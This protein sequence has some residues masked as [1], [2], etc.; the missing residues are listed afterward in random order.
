MSSFTFLLPILILAAI[1]VPMIL[2][3]LRKAKAEREGKIMIGM[4]REVHQTGTYINEQPVLRVLMDAQSA[5]GQ[6]LQTTLK[7]VFS[8]VDPPRAGMQLPIVLNPQNPAEAFLASD[9][10]LQR[11]DRTAEVLR[12]V[13]AVPPKMRGNKP[14]VGDIVAIT[15]LPDGK[16]SYQV[17]V[18]R[19]NRKPD[20]VFCTQQFAPGEAAFS[21]GDRV[22]LVTDA[23]VP[24]RSGY[25]MPLSFS[26][27]LRIP[28]TGNRLDSQVL[29]DELLFSGAKATGTLQTAVEEPLPPGYRER[30]FSKWTLALHVVPDDGSRSYDA[31]LSIGASTPEK[32]ARLTE[33]GAKLPL[34]YDT[35][36]LLMVTVDTIAMGFGDPQLAKEQLKKVVTSMS[37]Q[38][39]HTQVRWS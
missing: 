18:V 7:Q 1:F 35:N 25:I 14:C 11:N 15:P 20:T 36:D 12:S 5:D 19:I 30:G 3:R 6:Q 32:A 2:R 21:V 37:G 34:R 23:E 33:F 4:V 38:P 29:A 24:P 17:D 16:S 27:G 10:A 31:T 22:Y 8:L 39:G 9:R 28:K 26:A 13:A